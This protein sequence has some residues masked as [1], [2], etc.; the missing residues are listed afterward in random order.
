MPCIWTT[1]YLCGLF[2][3]K[4]AI[5]NQS[6]EN[7]TWITAICKEPLRYAASF[8]NSA[9]FQQQVKAERKIANC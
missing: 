4:L 2:S 1:C 9:V 7:N 5:F 8:N 3:S 6:F